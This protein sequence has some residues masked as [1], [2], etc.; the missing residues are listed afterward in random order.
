MTTN[1]INNL[2]DLL[3]E[4]ARVQAQIQIVEKE[5]RISAD[6]TRTELSTFVDNK[7]SI[8]KQLGQLFQGSD[9][10]PSAGASAIGAISKVAGLGPWWSG[11]LATLAPM[12][13]NYT[14]DQLR[15]RKERKK[16]QALTAAETTPE[17]TE[18][19]SPPNKKRGFFK[20]KSSE[21][22]AD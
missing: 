7:F 12:L 11:I 1:K 18:D 10:Q 19:V 21:P 6:R 3:E 8:P 9:K 22:T 5:L 15:K 4:K 17:N 14:Q 20:R 13:V 2:E 16:M